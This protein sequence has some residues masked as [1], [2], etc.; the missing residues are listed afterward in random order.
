VVR[1][2]GG[3]PRG[4]GGLRRSLRLEQGEE[5]RGRGAIK[6]GRAQGWLSPVKAG[7]SAVQTNSARTMTHQRQGADKRSGCVKERQ[8]CFDADMRGAERK[9]GGAERRPA[10]F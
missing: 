10:P 5:V 9:K 3:A 4:G 1:G 7:D 6:S 8:R 2:G